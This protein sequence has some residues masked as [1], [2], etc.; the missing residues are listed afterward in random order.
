MLE[1]QNTEPP[2]LP[3]IESLILQ[4]VQGTLARTFSMP[5]DRLVFFASTNRMRIAEQVATLQKGLSGGIV[6]PVML[7][8]MNS[9]SL[10]HTEGGHSYNTR[11]LARHGVYLKTA[12]SGLRV[13]KHNLVPT[14]TEIE[15]I[16]MTDAFAQ[17]FAYA[18]AWM[19]HAINARLNFTATY[20]NTG[21][22]IRTE[23]STQVSTP[24][25]EESV[26]QPNVF[27]YTGT[28]KIYGYTSDP[29]VDG[30][31]YIQVLSKPVL[32]VS[33]DAPGASDLHVYD[34]RRPTLTT[35][36]TR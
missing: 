20:M 22:D 4:G 25:R 21:F 17:A 29:H 10:G 23:M 32:N 28:V 26:D 5:S 34:P 18:N 36:D 24:D 3:P 1:T 12:E 33:I 31:S 14:V 11:S 19:A 35:K 2:T 7:L 30:T 8:H 6:W 9:V 13:L 16:Y 27:E 15:V